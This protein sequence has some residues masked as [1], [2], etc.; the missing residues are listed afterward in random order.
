MTNDQPTE[1]RQSGISASAIL[2]VLIVLLGANLAALTSGATPPVPDSSSEAA[3][4]SEPAPVPTDLPQGPPA[5]GPAVEPTPEALPSEAPSPARAERPAPPARRRRTIPLVPVEERLRVFAGLSTWI[6]L[7]DVEVT[8]EQQVAAAAR[9]GVQSVFVQTARFNSKPIED[10]DRLARVIEGAHDHGMRVM[11]WYVP[12]FVNLQRDYNRS[13]KAIAFQTPRGDRPDA[14]GLDIEVE[15]LANTRQRTRR[16]L[17]LSSALRQ[18]V[19]PDYP[20]AAIVLP[21]LQ[22]DMRPGWWPDFPYAQL[23]DSYDVFIPMSYSSFRG[24]DRRTTYRWNLENVREMRRRAG[25]DALLVHLAGGIADNLPRLGA[26][27]AAARDADVL[28]AGLYDLDT[29][30]RRDWRLLRRLRAEP[31]G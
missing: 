20:M 3:V 18:W 23:R 27:L 2:A 24:T 14:F 7:Y 26:F 12:D 13:V 1:R 4:A 30:Q 10:P 29:T 28:G 31:S 9:G 15:H 17:E 22:L 21:P 5:E 19:G 8:P 6:D 16:L 11:V 25:D